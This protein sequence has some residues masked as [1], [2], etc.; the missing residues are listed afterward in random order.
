M[1]KI[2]FLLVICIKNISSSDTQASSHAIDTSVSLTAKIGALKINHPFFSQKKQAGQLAKRLQSNLKAVISESSSTDTHTHKLVDLVTDLTKDKTLR[3]YFPTIDN[4]AAVLKRL[5]HCIDTQTMTINVLT[6]PDYSG[7][8]K[9]EGK[10]EVW[11]FDFKSLGNTEGFIAQRSHNYVV[12]LY[13]TA[14][15]YIPHVQIN[16]YLPSFEFY[17][18]GFTS[19]EEKL[20]YARCLEQLELSTHCIKKMYTLSSIPDAQVHI[21]S[22]RMS[23]EDFHLKK[24]EYFQKITHDEVTHPDW[25]TFKT[26]TFK[27]RKPMYQALYP[28]KIFESD[29]EYEGRLQKT[30]DRQIAEYCTDGDVFTQNSDEILVVADSPIMSEAYGLHNQPVIFGKSATSSS[31]TGE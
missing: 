24:E 31:Y 6:C 4:D 8:A 1:K 28:Q 26:S 13:K 7:T 18:D 23:D 2:L 3:T 30:L 25:R 21:T 16:H 14:K 5:Q 17:E 9:Q 20:S 11:T 10:Q 27:V 19:S 29:T 22:T 15:K 12:N